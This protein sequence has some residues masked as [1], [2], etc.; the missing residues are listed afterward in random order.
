MR[1]NISR[2]DFHR[3][4]LRSPGIWPTK[5]ELRGM[6]WQDD[7]PTDLEEHA[8]Y[9]S[10]DNHEDLVE[11]TFIEERTTMLVDGPFTRHEAAKLCQCRADELVPSPLGA[12]QEVDKVRTIFD[13]SVGNQNQHIRSNTVERTT[14]PTVLDCTTALHWL[15]E[16]RNRQEITDAHGS[17]HPCS[18]S[19]M[20]PDQG[21]NWVLLKA[22]TR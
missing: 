21:T 8:N 12:I 4:T 2:C 20:H 13:G 7:A 1:K 17:E 16:A 15:H 9:P 10:A 3:P 14:A 5:D 11:E 6:A 19:W 18:N 22:D